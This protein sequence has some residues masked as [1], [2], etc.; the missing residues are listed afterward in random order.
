M[1][2]MSFKGLIDTWSWTLIVFVGGVS[3][4]LEET[5]ET[6]VAPHQHAGEQVR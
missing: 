3:T 2:G 6:K 5:G 1:E 4:A